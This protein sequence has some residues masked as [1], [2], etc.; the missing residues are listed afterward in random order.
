VV[1]H[2]EVT[3]VLEPDSIDCRMRMNTRRIP[4]IGGVVLAFSLGAAAAEEPRSAT[5]R[6]VA[7]GTGRTL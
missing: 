3:T 1:T 6:A 2:A 7:A 5:S 4:G